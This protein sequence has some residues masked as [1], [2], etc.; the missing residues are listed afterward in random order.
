MVVRIKTQS[1]AWQMGAT[2]IL[3]ATVMAGLAMIAGPIMVGSKGLLPGLLAAL[4]L[5]IAA[6]VLITIARGII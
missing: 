4:A 5:G 2:L 6:A 3:T 1:Y